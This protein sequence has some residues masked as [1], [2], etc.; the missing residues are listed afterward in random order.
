MTKQDREHYWCK[1]RY[2]HPFNGGF[3][4]ECESHNCETDREATKECSG[5]ELDF[6]EIEW[7]AQSI[8]KDLEDNFKKKSMLDPDQSYKEPAF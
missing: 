5:Y 2:N 3:C 4:C 7:K 1:Y 6:S 8:K